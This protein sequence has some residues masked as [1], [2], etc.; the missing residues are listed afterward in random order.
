[1]DIMDDVQV[2]CVY[3]RCVYLIV[4]DIGK[5]LVSVLGQQTLSVCRE[6]DRSVFF[7]KILCRS[8]SLFVA[9]SP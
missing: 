4:I 1:M 8:A 5:H 6:R 7:T 3:K 2:I 9:V